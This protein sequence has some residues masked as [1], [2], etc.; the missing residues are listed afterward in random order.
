MHIIYMSQPKECYVYLLVC[1]SGATYVGATV[2]LDHRL[3][4]HNKELAGGAVQTSRKVAKGET[5]R[6]HCYIKNIPD[7]KTALQVEWAW[8]F[9][10]RKLGRFGPPLDRRLNALEVLLSLD[11]ATSNAIP[12]SEWPV[13]PEVVFEDYSS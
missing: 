6:R 7:W 9:Q 11:R 5:W 10:Y 2:D 3:R 8:K 13:W 4:Q 1:D 12:Y